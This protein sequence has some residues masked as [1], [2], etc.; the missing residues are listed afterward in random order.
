LA[1]KAGEVAAIY[2]LLSST[3]KVTEIPL[4]WGF[5]VVQGN[6][7]H[8]GTRIL[9]VAADSQPAIE[10]IKDVAREQYQILLYSTPE[11]NAET[12]ASLRCKVLDA[13][14]WVALF[15]VTAEQEQPS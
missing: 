11:M 8:D 15:A 7:I 2:Q 10:Y 4:R 1:G 12:I 9:P 14:N 13:R 6:M 5:E 3:G